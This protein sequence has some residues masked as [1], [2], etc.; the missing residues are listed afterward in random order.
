MKSLAKVTEE[1]N[2]LGSSAWCLITYHALA[3][4]EISY[5]DQSYAYS[6][7]KLTTFF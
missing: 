1:F 3:S 2:S 4:T 6:E 5:S 7:E